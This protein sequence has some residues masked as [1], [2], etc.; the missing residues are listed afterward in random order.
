MNRDRVGS[1]LD[2]DSEFSEFLPPERI[3]EAR[4][5]LYVRTRRLR[6]GIWDAELRRSVTRQHLGLLVVDGVLA[7]DIVM[8][9]AVSTEL[10]GPGDVIRPWT[11]H[12]AS[13]LV[14]H[15]V[16]W[17]VLAPTRIALLDQS[18]ATALVRHPEVNAMLIERLSRRIHRLALTQAITGLN[19]VD[20]RLLALFWHLAELWGRMTPQGIVIPMTLSHRMLGQLVSARRPTI[21]TA[22]AGLAEDGELER[23]PNGCWLLTGKPMSASS[24]D[25]EAVVPPR[26]RFLVSSSSEAD[27]ASLL[28]GGFD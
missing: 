25:L 17:T 24:S 3:P 18:F 9:G 8:E 27:R 14:P 26:R 28:P 7:R 10:V 20:R 21:S 6:V 22:L 5:D 12:D 2:L 4:R 23:L 13:R 11:R 16:Q 15:A 1:L 19:R